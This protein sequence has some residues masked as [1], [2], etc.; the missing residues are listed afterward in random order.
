MMIFPFSFLFY[1]LYVYVEVVVWRSIPKHKKKD[2]HFLH[3]I[4]LHTDLINN[5]R[6]T[7][8]VFTVGL[9]KGFYSGLVPQKFTHPPNHH[10]GRKFNAYWCIIW[11]FGFSNRWIVTFS[12]WFALCYQLFNLFLRLTN[13]RCN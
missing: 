6:V 7:H 2:G 11:Q 3:Y 8:T 10:E 1:W 5:C 12:Y 4:A 13:N 9:W